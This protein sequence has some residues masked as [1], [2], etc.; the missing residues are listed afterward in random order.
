[1]DVTVNVAGRDLLAVAADVEQAIQQVQFPLEYRAELRGEY[2]VRR[3]AQRRVLAFGIAAAIGIFLLLQAFFKSWPLATVVFLTLPAGLVGGVLAL[4][5]SGGGLLSLGSIAGF[6]AVLGM[7]VRN[8][9]LLVSRYRH[10]EQHDGEAFGAALVQ[11]GTQER[12]APILMSAIT[13]ALAFLPFALFGN[14]AGLE[15]AHPMAIV[16]LGGLVT[17]TLVSLVGV[18]A[19]CVVCGAAKAEPDMELVEDVP[20]TAV[21]A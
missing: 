9:A 5:L 18:P 10:L 11:H 13:T 2:A 19:M 6:V 3:A 4:L 16:V 8:T 12:S 21:A 20:A 14:I 7:A 17:T 15:I 1:V